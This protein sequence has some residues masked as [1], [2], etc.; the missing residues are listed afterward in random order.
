M[1][2]IFTPKLGYSCKIFDSLQLKMYSAA[3]RPKSRK[4][5]LNVLL[6]YERERKEEGARMELQP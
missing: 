2:I 4:L 1:K 5:K 3:E 6:T